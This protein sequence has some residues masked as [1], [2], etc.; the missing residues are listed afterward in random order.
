M[1]LLINATASLS[2]IKAL[3]WRE[4]TLRRPSDNAGAST[5]AGCTQWTPADACSIRS[6][7]PCCRV[8]LLPPHLQRRFD[9]ELTSHRPRDRNHIIRSRTETDARYLLH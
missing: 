9:E 2:S 3:W 7:P 6:S 5:Q 4:S 8:H 1:S